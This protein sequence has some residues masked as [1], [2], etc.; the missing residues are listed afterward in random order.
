MTALNN[1]DILYML[2]SLYCY[3]PVQVGSRR[4]IQV[5]GSIMILLG[6][7]GKFGA[8]FVMI[9]TPVIGGMQMIMLGRVD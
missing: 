2:M 4:V 6:C 9:P 1:D 3:I 8:L 5:G 7:L